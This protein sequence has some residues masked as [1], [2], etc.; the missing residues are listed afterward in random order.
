MYITIHIPVYHMILHYSLLLHV[1]ISFNNHCV[2]SICHNIYCLVINVNL[3][4]VSSLNGEELY[5]ECL[6]RLEQERWD[7]T[8]SLVL[9]FWL[10]NLHI[11]AFVHILTVRNLCQYSEGDI[12]NVV[13]LVINFAIES[14]IVSN[15]MQAKYI[16]KV[17]MSNTNV[18]QCLCLHTQWQCANI[19]LLHMT[20][21]PGVT[22]FH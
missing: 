15:V 16:F 6:Y 3:V 1:P 21:I 13:S 20:A 19:I 12:Q 14:Y 4:A 2:K 9:V 17:Y 11:N 5:V 7:H 10:L 22:N 18:T 8:L